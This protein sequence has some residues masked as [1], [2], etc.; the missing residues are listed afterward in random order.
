MPI[1]KQPY[2]NSET[3]SYR[4]EPNVSSLLVEEGSYIDILDD[5]SFYVETL[6]QTY[7]V[8]L[9]E[10]SFF[11][12]FKYFPIGVSNV[13]QN[14][15]INVK[16]NTRLSVNDISLSGAYLDSSEI[17]PST[18]LMPIVCL[19]NQEIYNISPRTSEVNCV[20]LTKNSGGTVNSGSTFG[21]AV[22]PMFAEKDNV[23]YFY[24]D[25]DTNDLIFT[26]YFGYKSNIHAI[27]NAFSGEKDDNKS[28]FYA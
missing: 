26:N 13:D 22:S 11:Y 24:L 3:G 6:G 12:N 8:I 15:V 2:S 20:S 19:N 5:G 4:I 28:E 21:F 1:C 16:A 9:D 17:N 10:G 27:P 23:Y 14:A 18:G 25:E 7:K